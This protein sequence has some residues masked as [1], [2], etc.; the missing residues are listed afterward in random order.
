MGPYLR[1][2]LR[3]WAF[4]RQGKVELVYLMIMMNNLFF[5]TWLFLWI[6]V[7]L[8][9]SAV[10]RGDLVVV[11]RVWFFFCF[12]SLM[13]LCQ[14]TTDQLMI[15]DCK[16]FWFSALHG[17]RHFLLKKFPQTPPDGVDALLEFH[18]IRP[19]RGV[20]EQ[21]L[22][23]IRLLI[24]TEARQSFRSLHR[25]EEEGPCDQAIQWAASATLNC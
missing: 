23:Q 14:K 15:T 4:W 19:L 8:H 2:C 9:F 11:I 21:F 17:F 6:V 12:F 1:M 13:T 5:T 16:T 22:N 25:K 24:A 10:L 18:C 20:A 7:E 3:L